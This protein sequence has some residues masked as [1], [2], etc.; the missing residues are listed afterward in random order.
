[1]SKKFVRSIKHVNDVS[2]LS[3]SLIEEN[4]IVSTKDGLIYI[5][6]DIKGFLKV[7]SDIDESLIET[8]KEE[9]KNQNETI[10]ENKTTIETLKDE[11]KAQNET[12]KENKT[13]IETFE[14][15]TTDYNNRM[16]SLEKKSENNRNDI[17]LI[18][19]DFKDF[20]NDTGWIN[21]TLNDGYT[22]HTEVPQYRFIK[23]GNV[24]SIT[25]RGSVKGIKGKSRQTIANI[26]LPDEFKL[27]HYYVNNSTVKNGIINMD[28]WKIGSDGNLVF[29]GSTNNALD[30]TEWHRIDTV[31]YT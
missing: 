18:K 17:V 23:I 2:K 25:F 12:I 11:N 15:K 20:I 13:K 7:G 3:K 31:F 27:T 28:R 8:L 19:Q 1:M 16:T 5:Y 10:K 24:I 9:N 26:P 29:E 4:D 21:L 6:S 22:K 30:G 14:E